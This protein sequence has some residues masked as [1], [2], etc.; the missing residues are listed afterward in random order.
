MVYRAHFAMIRNPL[1]TSDG[2]HTSALFGFL[3]SMFKIL[4]DEK[5]DYIGA[6]FDGKEKTFRHEKYPEYKATREKMPD[7]LREQLPDLWRLIEAM[8]I[9]QMTKEGFEADDLIGTLAVQAEKEGL[10]TYI[11]S[12][13][14]DF[15]QLVNYSVFVYTP[16]R[17][18]NPTTIFDREKVKEKW[19]VPPEK[20]IDL[21]GLMGDSSDNVPGVRG[22]GAKT[23]V[24]L[25]NEYGTV[26]NILDHAEEVKNK[27]AREGLLNGKELALLSRELVTI[28]TDVPLE[29]SVDDLKQ[30]Q[31][32]FDSMT[33]LFREFEFFRMEKQ[34]NDFR[35]A[36]SGRDET[37]DE[38]E[39]T[40]NK[41]LETRNEISKN[42]SCVDSVRK[43]GKLISGIKKAKLVSVDIESTSTDPMTAEIV[44]FSYS[45][46]SDE[47]WYVPIQFPE[48]GEQLFG[49]EDDLKTVLDL[50]KPILEDPKIPKCGQ[51]I[52]YD[53]L[54]LK[55][56]GIKLQG[57]AFDTMIAAHLLKP[58][59]RSY[60]L[61][62]L[63]LEYLKFE[64]QPITDLIGSGRNQISMSEVPVE[65]V[66]HYAAEDADI[67]LQLVP[68]LKKRLK[69]DQL[70]N[71]AEDIEFPMIPVLLQM[72]HDGVYVEKPMMEEMSLWMEKKLDT[73]TRE[74]HSLAGTEFNINSPQQ[75]AVILFDRLS[76]P[77]IRQRS[78][79]VNVLKTLKY[80]HPLPEKVLGYR[81]FQKLKST[82]VDAI[83]KLIHPE[84]DRIHSSFS[85]TVAATGRLS[86]SNPNFQNIPIREEEGREIRKAFR[87]QE[88][89]W[90]IFSADYSQIELRIMAHISGDETLKRAFLEGE[91]IHAHTAS[92]IYGVPVE[93]VLPEM[94]RTAKV[95]NFGVMYGA[96]PFRMSQE[97][98][99]PQRES[100]IVIK[101]YFD[102]Y[103]G[104]RSYIDS[105]LKKARNENYVET[106]LGRRRY[107]Y[108]INN[109]NQRIR[110]AVERAVINMPIQGTAAEMIKLAMIKIHEKLIN[111]KTKMILQIHDELLFEVPDDELG[112]V[113]QMVIEEMESAMTLDIPIVVDSGVGESWFEAH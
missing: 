52:K 26:E 99:I 64:M 42:Y 47:G 74:I 35:G 98:G 63:S 43:M 40:R 82:Y 108:D 69:E 86:S 66:T 20:M 54:I 25:L 62:Y 1:I 17:M 97:L 61:D 41:K 84:T 76:L 59:E 90:V 107:C 88:K 19:S 105:T 94:R 80:Q 78:T 104:I 93:N 65:K 71:V 13:D 85:Q 11:V 53:A 44:G 23:A 34:L 87:T 21:L 68:L 73:F 45:V 109:T 37:R 29:L 31:F 46:K 7:E 79:D 100:K 24:K 83:P 18:N 72:E 48:K 75:M 38:S 58:E 103:P 89:G 110:T 92:N 81:K 91:D 51:N 12:G 5:P 50:I 27:R 10:E 49:G 16:G 112:E 113:K 60:K 39:E 67:A 2:R 32:D 56:H 9:P 101:T 14:K 102:R 28:K 96:G 3:N 57:I 22:V 15:M 70:L 77:K 8:N 95:V 33:E 6:I 111:L 55:R 30:K 4:R 106:M 36:A